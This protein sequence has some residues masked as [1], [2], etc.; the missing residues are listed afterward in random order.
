MGLAQRRSRENQGII[1]MIWKEGTMFRTVEQSR[2]TING[3]THGFRA[4]CHLG[5]QSDMDLSVAY[6]HEG[7]SWNFTFRASQ[8]PNERLMAFHAFIHSLI[9]EKQFHKL[10]KD[11]ERLSL[12]KTQWVVR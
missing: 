3:V 9:K 12:W 6:R 10:T 5:F 8:T 4:I 1:E 2:W 7:I 11:F